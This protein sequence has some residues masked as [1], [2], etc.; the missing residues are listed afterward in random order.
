MVRSTMVLSTMAFLCEATSRLPS[1]STSRNLICAAGRAARE[2]GGTGSWR[3]GRR[4][5]QGASHLERLPNERLRRRL[6]WQVV[7][8]GHESAQ[9]LNLQHGTALVDRH[10]LGVHHAVLAV[11]DSHLQEERGGGGAAGL[12]EVAVQGGGGEG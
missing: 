12:V 5:L 2:W 4:G 3:Q 7:R 9:P 11:H 6:A 10:D 8:A 1:L